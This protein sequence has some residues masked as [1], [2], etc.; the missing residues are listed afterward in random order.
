MIISYFAAARAATGI[1]QETLDL[2]APL[3]FSELLEQLARRHPSPASVGVPALAELLGR[4]SF[5]RNEVALRELATVVRNEDLIDVLPP[6]AG[7]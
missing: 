7:G 2:P 3:P 1:E 4:C 6:F 5:L